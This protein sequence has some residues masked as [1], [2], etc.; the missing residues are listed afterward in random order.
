[1][2]ELDMPD[3]WF[4]QDGASCHTTR[5]TMAQLRAAFGEQFISRFGPVNLPPRSCDLTPLDYF[6]WSHVKAGR[7]QQRLTHWEP[8]LKHLFVKYRLICWRECAEI[9]PCEWAI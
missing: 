8:I 3:M 4:Q 6:L 2:E 7:T 9:G 5:E 1:M